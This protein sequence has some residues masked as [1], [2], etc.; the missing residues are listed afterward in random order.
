MTNRS[1]VSL[2]AIVCVPLLAVAQGT[3]QGD[4]Q[5]A[6]RPSERIENLRKVRLVEIL[7]L[8]EDQSVRFLARMN[9]HDAARRDLMK[10]RGDALD[11]LERLIRNKAEDSEYEKAFADVAAIDDRIAAERKG[12]FSGL[13]DILTP[14]QRA[15][16]LIF[17]RRFEREL[18]E[19]MREAQK[20]RREQSQQPQ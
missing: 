11:R 10:Q 5:G 2:A 18:R 20:R 3:G 13:S 14:T 9:E 4:Q 8:K 19:A 17:E 15:K 1:L 6:D 7:E 16:M 12:F